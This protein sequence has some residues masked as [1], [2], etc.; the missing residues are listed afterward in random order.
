[1][2]KIRRCSRIGYFTLIGSIIFDYIF[3]LF[4]KSAWYPFKEVNALF[5]EL[6]FA[7]FFFRFFNRFMINYHTRYRPIFYKPSINTS[8][9]NDKK[10][11]FRKKISFSNWFFLFKKF[12]KFSKNRKNSKTLL[13][14]RKENSKFE[15]QISRAFWCIIFSV[16]ISI[17]L[18]VSS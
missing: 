7:W 3:P 14:F 1:M 9:R 17:S 18:T 15:Y 16:Y 12:E 2:L 8:D 4:F 13:F 10:K 5:K 6:F 11:I